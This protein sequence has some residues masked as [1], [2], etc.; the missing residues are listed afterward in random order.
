MSMHTSIGFM[1]YLQNFVLMLVNQLILL[2]KFV[3]MSLNNIIMFA[4]YDSSFSFN[5]LTFYTWL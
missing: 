1:S 2:I 4:I 5:F 3:S